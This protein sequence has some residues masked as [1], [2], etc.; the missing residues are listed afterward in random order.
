MALFEDVFEGW[1]GAGLV[2][3]GAVIA[4]PL[5]LPVVGTVIRPVVKGV[6][7]SS[8]AVAG[9]ARELWAEAG[10]QLS[11]L[12]AEARDEYD[13]GRGTSTATGQSRIITPEG[14]SPA[15]A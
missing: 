15:E 10:E 8:L 1:T 7:R 2:G 11:D 12:Y 5:L 6:I 13:R 3:L 4:A 9:G 14:Q